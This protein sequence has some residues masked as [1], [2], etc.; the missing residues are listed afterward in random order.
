MAAAVLAEG[1]SVVENCPGFPIRTYDKDIEIYR[2]RGMERRRLP[3]YRLV[4]P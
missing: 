4:K 3:L 1:I 2:L